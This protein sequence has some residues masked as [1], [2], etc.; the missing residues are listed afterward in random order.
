M[1]TLI[2]HLYNEKGPTME[3]RDFL[4]LRTTS[5]C[6][7]LLPGRKY[8]NVLPPEIPQLIWV[9]FS[10]ASWPMY[11]P[12]QK[13]KVSAECM[14]N[15]QLQKNIRFKFEKG[16]RRKQ[17][18]ILRHNLPSFQEQDIDADIW[19]WLNLGI[20]QQHAKY[21]CLTCTE[22]YQ[23]RWSLPRISITMLRKHWQESNIILENIHIRQQILVKRNTGSF[24]IIDFNHIQV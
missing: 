6:Q 3:F 14:L 21:F 24:T 4:S 19:I 12:I 15:K 16:K 22:I 9:S 7:Q 20:L 10:N 13:T 5:M 2:N 23:D 17:T 11:L 1:Q 8:W 18:T